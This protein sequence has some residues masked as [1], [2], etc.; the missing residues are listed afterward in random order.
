MEH[1]DH[2]LS[3]PSKGVGLAA[4]ERPTLR[5]SQPDLDAT[6]LG[7]EAVAD[8]VMAEISKSTIGLRSGSKV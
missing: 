5:I 3:S 7:P 4:T 8:L 1:E 6:G 2:N